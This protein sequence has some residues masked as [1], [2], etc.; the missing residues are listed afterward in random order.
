MA[1]DTIGEFVGDDDYLVVPVLVLVAFFVDHDFDGGEAE[2]GDFGVDCGEAVFEE[3]A[4]AFG[5]GD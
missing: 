1:F 5:E 4:D 3:G 2:V